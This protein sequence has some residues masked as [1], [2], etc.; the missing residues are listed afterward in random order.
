M[1]KTASHR[2]FGGN[3]STA[4]QDE[5]YRNRQEKLSYTA[6]PQTAM[7]PSAKD[8]TC[9]SWNRKCYA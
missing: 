7:V 2:R 8:K 3:R 5:N 4:V 6:I 1:L 9:F